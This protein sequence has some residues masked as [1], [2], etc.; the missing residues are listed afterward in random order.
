MFIRGMW[1]KPQEIINYKNDGD[2][3]FID[4]LSFTD[5]ELLEDWDGIRLRFY[6]Q[7]HTVNADGTT[8]FHHMFTLLKGGE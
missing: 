5:Q 8:C 2:I 3:V 6:T 7:Y 4:G 1:Y